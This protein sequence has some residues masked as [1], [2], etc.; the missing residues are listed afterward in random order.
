VCGYQPCDKPT[1]TWSEQHRFECEA[2]SVMRKPSD[3][4]QAYYRDVLKHRGQ[5]GRQRLVDEVNRQWSISIIGN[6]TGKKGTPG[7][8]MQG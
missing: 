6:A 8:G 7:S 3:V 4:R 2:R 5:D 1:C